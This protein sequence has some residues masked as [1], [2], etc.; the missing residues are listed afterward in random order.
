MVRFAGA[1][2]VVF[3]ATNA[4]C[5]SFFA[6]AHLAFCAL[7]IFNREAFD[8]KR[9][10]TDGDADADVMLVAWLACRDVP[11]PFSD[12]ITEIA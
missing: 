12:S 5:D 2:T 3:A 10:G 8:I 11:V 9:F 1:A 4:G 6:F 7:A